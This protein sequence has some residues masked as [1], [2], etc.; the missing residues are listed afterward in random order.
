MAV[1]KPRKQA[2][3]RAKPVTR[4]IQATSGTPA[5]KPYFKGSKPSR[6]GRGGQTRRA[7]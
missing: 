6:A 2:A 5:P 4:K 7:S 1:P 3:T